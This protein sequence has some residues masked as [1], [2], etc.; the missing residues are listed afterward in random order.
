MRLAGGSVRPDVAA[1][2]LLP[3]SVSWSAFPRIIVRIW[4]HVP[5]KTT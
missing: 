5:E 4:T 1:H 2:M 3:N